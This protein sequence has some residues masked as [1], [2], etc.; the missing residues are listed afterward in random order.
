MVRM[1][2]QSRGSQLGYLFGSEAQEQ[3]TSNT[4]AIQA[5]NLGSSNPNDE[6]TPLDC[7]AARCFM[8]YS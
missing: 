1:V 5:F 7:A 2:A 3:V 6:V 4:W 8:D